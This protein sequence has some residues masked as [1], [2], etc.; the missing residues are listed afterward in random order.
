MENE[1][2]EPS[3]QAKRDIVRLEGDRP[4]AINLDHVTHMFIEGKRIT[5]NFYNS[6]SF[7]DIIDEEKAKNVFQSIINLWCGDVVE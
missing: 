6:A 5:F 1:K 4:T 2:T 3:R 7:I